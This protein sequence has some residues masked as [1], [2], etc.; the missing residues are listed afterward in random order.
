MKPDA[1]IYQ[2]AVE[3]AGCRPEECFYTDDILENVEGGLREGLDAVVFQ[4][5]EQIEQ[6]MN[7]RGIRWE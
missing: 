3:R 2:A 5:R 7:K 4:S 1:R 6:E